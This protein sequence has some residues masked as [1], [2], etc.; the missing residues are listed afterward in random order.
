MKALNELFSVPF[1]TC[2]QCDK[3]SRI[4]L[5]Y[6]DIEAS[7]RINDFLSF[8][9]LINRIDLRHK[10]FDLTDEGDY[11]SVE[12]PKLNLYQKLGLCE[13]IQLRELVNGTHFAIELNSMLHEVLYQDSAIA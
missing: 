7:F 9:K 13:F 8:R 4:L 1:G 5:Q 3:T 11:A 6:K 12:V 10:L 2:H